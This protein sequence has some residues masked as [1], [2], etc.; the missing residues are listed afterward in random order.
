MTSDADIA[1]GLLLLLL[2]MCLLLVSGQNTTC[3]QPADTR[4]GNVK[5]VGHKY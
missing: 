1:V 4:R 3:P 5:K 2:L